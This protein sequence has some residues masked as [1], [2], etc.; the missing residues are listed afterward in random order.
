LSVNTPNHALRD[1]TRSDIAGYSADR[2]TETKAAFK[3][4]EFV[5]F[6]VAV[7]GVLIASA[8]VGDSD[9]RGD[10]FLAD[11]A[12]LYVTLLAV[13]YMISRGLAKSGVRAH[14]DV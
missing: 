11:K 5:V 7:V 2:G 4:T 9:G 14:H 3:T 1:E 6:V 12:W 8:L 10:V 13:G